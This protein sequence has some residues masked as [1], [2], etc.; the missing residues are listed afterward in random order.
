MIYMF[1]ALRA[2]NSGSIIRR[3]YWFEY[4]VCRKNRIR[5]LGCIHGKN[6]LLNP[7]SNKTSVV[8]LSAE[9]SMKLGSVCIKHILHRVYFFSHM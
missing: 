6:K 3:I 5:E 1:T 2:E 8:L 7:S 9:Y 4:E